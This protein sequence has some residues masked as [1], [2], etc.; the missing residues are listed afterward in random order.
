MFTKQTNLMSQ[1]MHLPCQSGKPIFLRRL[2]VFRS[3]AFVIDEAAAVKIKG[4]S[5]ATLFGALSLGVHSSSPIFFIII[6]SSVRV[7]PKISSE[8]LRPL[9]RD[10]PFGHEINGDY[11]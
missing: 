4:R 5:L 2:L 1:P 6:I 10:Y 7:F 11:L 8:G 3:S 9:I